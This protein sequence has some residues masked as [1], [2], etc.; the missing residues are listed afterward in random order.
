MLLPA[1]LADV[2]RC[3]RTLIRC[4]C[5]FSDLFVDKAQSTRGLFLF[6]FFFVHLFATD[7]FYFRSQGASG[8]SARDEKYATKI[9]HVFLD[10]RHPSIFIR[11]HVEHQRF[12]TEVTNFTVLSIEKARNLTDIDFLPN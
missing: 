1:A 8:F 3:T 9:H 7:S 6:R 10:Q 5:A 4:C 11:K 12:G 2:I